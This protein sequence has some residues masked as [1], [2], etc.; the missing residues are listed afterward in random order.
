MD[1]Q[2]RP[3]G[4]ESQEQSGQSGPAEQRSRLADSW[5]EVGQQISDLFEKVSAAFRAA[6][7]EERQHEGEQTARSLQ[8]DLR[9]TADRLERVMKRVAQETEEERAATLGTTRNVSERT[10]AEARTAAI[11]GLR[12]LNQQLEQLLGRL[13]RPHGTTEGSSQQTGMSGMGEPSGSGES[14]ETTG[15]SGTIVPPPSS[16]GMGTGMSTGM[17]S[18]PSSDASS[19]TTEPPRS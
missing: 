6:W 18:E 12:T 8:N 3:T 10:V 4:Q 19:E 14:S 7:S 2:S 15:S 5:Q 1:E 11:G 17:G 9:A 16:T 13:D